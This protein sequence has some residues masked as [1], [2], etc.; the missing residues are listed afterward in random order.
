MTFA[1][2]AIACGDSTE[3][4]NL[5]PDAGPRTLMD[6][7]IPSEADAMMVP[8]GTMEMGDAQILVSVTDCPSLC[9]RL[10]MCGNDQFGT[11]MIA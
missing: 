11:A 8:D 2:L 10:E 6:A 7:R 4:V 3:N 9:S 1:I 5:E